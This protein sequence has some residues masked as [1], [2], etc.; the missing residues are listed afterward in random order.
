M[1]AAMIRCRISHVVWWLDPVSDLVLR[2]RSWRLLSDASA[3]RL[4]MLLL[5]RGL[6]LDDDEPVTGGRRHG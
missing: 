2:L 5:A 3:M 1:T 4:M 6:R